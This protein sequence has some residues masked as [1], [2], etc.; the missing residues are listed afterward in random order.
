[1]STRKTANSPLQVRRNLSRGPRGG[2][3]EESGDLSAID[4]AGS[5]ICAATARRTRSA[6]GRRPISRPF[7]DQHVHWKNCSPSGE[8][9]VDIESGAI[10]GSGVEEQEKRAG[11]YNDQAGFRLPRGGQEPRGRQRPILRPFMDLHVHGKNCKFTSTNA[12]AS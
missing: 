11:V 4:K 9:G 7:M 1:M 12:R 8:S 10:D 6:A 2:Q 5:V 3:R